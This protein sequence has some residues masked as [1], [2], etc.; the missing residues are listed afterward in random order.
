MVQRMVLL[1][2]CFVLVA[3]SVG[4][5]NAR[6]PSRNSQAQTK[7]DKT[8]DPKKALGSLKKSET[9]AKTKVRSQGV[10]KAA[11]FDYQS[12]PD[13]QGG[14]RVLF[15]KTEN[16]RGEFVTNLVPRSFTTVV[17]NLQKNFPWI[18]E[19]TGYGR[20]VYEYHGRLVYIHFRNRNGE[21]KVVGFSESADGL[22]TP[23]HSF[24]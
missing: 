16:I 24:H 21:P 2:C 14:F 18:V 3:C 6:E 17:S 1:L 9:K 20:P 8:Q 22:M 5:D 19:K 11:I 10:V 23:Y 4:R 12:L 13:D 15:K 7:L